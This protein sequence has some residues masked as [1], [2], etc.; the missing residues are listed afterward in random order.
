MSIHEGCDIE[1]ERTGETPRAQ[2]RPGIPD[3][4]WSASL[5]A[6]STVTRQA[7]PSSLVPWRSW[8][9]GRSSPDHPKPRAGVERAAGTFQARITQ[10]MNLLNLAPDIQ[11]ALLFLPLTLGGA[12]L[13]ARGT[14][15]PSPGFRT[16]S[17]S[18]RCGRSLPPGR[19]SS[20]LFT[21]A[22]RTSSPIPPS[23]F[24]LVA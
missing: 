14:Y 18:A 17:V 21:I 22:V 13:S 23:R 16:G 3:S 6:I 10:I 9:S 4:H 8:A 2:Q 11:E 20:R 5:L 7:P 12:I 1:T 24:R 15:V 19:V